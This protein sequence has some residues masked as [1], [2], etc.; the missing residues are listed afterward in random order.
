MTEK[1]YKA[2]KDL[3]WDH[4]IPNM[5]LLFMMQAPEKYFKWQGNCCRQAAVMTHMAMRNIESVCNPGHVV[6]RIITAYLISGKLKTFD[7]AFYSLWT[8]SEYLK[9]D[10]SLKQPKPIFHFEPHGSYNVCRYPYH[11][12]KMIASD[13]SCEFTKG[14][15]IKAHMV[16]DE[17]EYYTGLT[18]NQ[19]YNICLKTKPP[20]GEK[21]HELRNPHHFTACSG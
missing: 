13:M 6:E 2:V 3:L 21:L 19:I 1:R 11:L 20:T 5:R 15:L 4:L 9:V 17:P 12:N 7:H 10:M 18:M 8:G 14:K 16:V